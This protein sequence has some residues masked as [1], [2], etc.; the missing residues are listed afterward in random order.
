[1]NSRIA[2]SSE[3]TDSKSLQGLGIYNTCNDCT[4]IYKSEISEWAET[5]KLNKPKQQIV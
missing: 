3:I 4:C 5:I 2:G 1:M